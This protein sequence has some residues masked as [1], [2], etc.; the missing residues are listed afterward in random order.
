MRRPAG[1]VL[2]GKS[3]T[4]LFWREGQMSEQVPGSVPPQAPQPGTAPDEKTWAMLCHAVSFAG[5]IIPLGNIVGP[6]VIWLMKKDTMPLVDDQG[7]ESLNFQ[8]TMMFA[9]AISFVLMLILIGF[10]LVFAVGIFDI[11]MTIIAIVKVSQ[12]ERYRY[13]ACIRFIK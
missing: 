13:P 9:V 5:I 1:A 11:V 7:K 4:G 12:G 10:V 8:I 3:R 6:L 2:A